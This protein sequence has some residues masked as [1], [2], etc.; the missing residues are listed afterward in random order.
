PFPASPWH[1]RQEVSYRNFPRLSD[2]DVPARG[3]VSRSALLRSAAGGAPVT[4]TVPGTGARL[5]LDGLK[6]RWWRVV[7]SQPTWCTTSCGLH[8]AASAS[9]ATAS[10]PALLRTTHFLGAGLTQQR[11]HLAPPLGS[12]GDED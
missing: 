10:A 12:A 6:L 1:T 7:A 8:A 9:A 5:R 11:L 2:S 3:C 4:G